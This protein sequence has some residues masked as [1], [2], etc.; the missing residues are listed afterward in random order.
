MPYKYQIHPRKYVNMFLHMYIQSIKFLA[1]CLIGNLDY[2]TEKSPG[3][4]LLLVAGTTNN[5]WW[6]GLLV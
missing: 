4:N 5:I 2:V 3:A 6:V 1:T